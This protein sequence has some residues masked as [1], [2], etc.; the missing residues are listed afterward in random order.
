MWNQQDATKSTSPAGTAPVAAHDR[1]TAEEP[2]TTA[3]IGKSVTIKGDVVSAED[4]SIDGRVE[5]TIVVG[6]HKLTIGAG[7]AINAELNARAIV[8]SGTVTGNVTATEKIEIR[9][10]G[11]VDGEL[12]MPR[13]SVREGAMLRGRIDT[14]TARADQKVTQFPQAV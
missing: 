12:K 9:E 14:G 5:G 4:L 6:D 13:L 10:T 2:R 11:S 7:A 8:I 1:Q 3:W